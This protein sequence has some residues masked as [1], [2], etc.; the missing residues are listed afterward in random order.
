MNPALIINAAAIVSTQM[1]I[2]TVAL[3]NQLRDVVFLLSKN[4]LQSFCC[5]FFLVSFTL[6]RSVGPIYKN[7]Q[8]F[9]LR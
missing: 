2:L 1:R 5:G 4:H 9:G 8:I 6:L 7:K 3:K